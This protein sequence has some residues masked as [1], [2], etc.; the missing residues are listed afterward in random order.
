MKIFLTFIIIFSSTAGFADEFQNGCFASK[1]QYEAKITPFKRDV[2]LSHFNRTCTFEEH[3][4]INNIAIK[5][6][7]DGC[8]IGNGILVVQAQNNQLTVNCWTSVGN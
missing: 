7:M 5:L 2:H 8:E 1:G 4:A 6:L 3:K